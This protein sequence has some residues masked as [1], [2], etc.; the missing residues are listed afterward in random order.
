MQVFTAVESAKLFAAMEVLNDPKR[1]YTLRELIKVDVR[2]YKEIDYEDLGRVLE[3]NKQ[4]ADAIFDALVTAAVYMKD[5]RVSEA[6]DKL[7]EDTNE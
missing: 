1:V 6:I 4:A 3:A 2:A 7:H 5:A